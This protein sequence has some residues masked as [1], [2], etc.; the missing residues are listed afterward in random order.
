L[1]PK[2]YERRRA[3]D[4]AKQD[5][6]DREK[7]FLN[8]YP[9]IGKRAQREFLGFGPGGGAFGLTFTTSDGKFDIRIIISNLLPNEVEMPDFDIIETAKRISQLY[10]RKSG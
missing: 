10:D 7:Y 2:E 3:Q 9:P 6:R 4:E 8:E 5:Y 1:D